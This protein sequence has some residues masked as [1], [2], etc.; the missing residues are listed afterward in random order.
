MLIL[1]II[2]I[3]SLISHELE[4]VCLSRFYWLIESFVSF[5]YPF[6][7]QKLLIYLILYFKIKL[8]KNLNNI[9][10]L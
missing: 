10:K 2:L 4:L 5:Y 8:V 3:V 6:E 1:I 9:K 7:N